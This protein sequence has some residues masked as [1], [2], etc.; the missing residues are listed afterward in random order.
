M[1]D[2]GGKFGVP[3]RIS[4]LEGG[5]QAVSEEEG[6]LPHAVKAVEGFAGRFGSLLLSIFFCFFVSWYPLFL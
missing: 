4:V 3:V 1:L 5:R 2:F 6:T